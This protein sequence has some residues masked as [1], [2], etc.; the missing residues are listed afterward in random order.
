MVAGKGNKNTENGA[1]SK[2]KSQGRPKSDPVEFKGYFNPTLTDDDKQSWQQWAAEP[3]A[4][5]EAFSEACRE[6]FKFTVQYDDSGH[7]YRATSAT[8]VRGHASAGVI[9]SLRGK[10]PFM[11][12]S[13]VV[14]CTVWR[15]AYNFNVS[16]PAVQEADP[17]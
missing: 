15:Y 1:A 3:D 10:D 5:T 17:W 6:G 14:W 4:F 8:W 2:G 7:C 12:L 16:T 9:V 11:A 13:R